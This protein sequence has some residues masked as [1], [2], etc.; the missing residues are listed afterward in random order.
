MNALLQFVRAR[1]PVVLLLVLLTGRLHA[2][3]VSEWPIP[4]TPNIQGLDALVPEDPT[5]LV[6]FT[7]YD[8]AKI[9][10]L[11]NISS[12]S[13]L[14]SEWFPIGTLNSFHPFKI[15]AGMWSFYSKANP[16]I[17]TTPPFA[18]PPIN[19]STKDLAAFV[20]AGSK[21]WSV[22]TFTMPDD[23]AIGMLIGSPFGPGPD[24]F[25]IWP[26]A[27][28]G[29]DQPWDIQRRN[30]SFNETSAWVSNRVP[31]QALYQFFPATS[32]LNKWD[33]GSCNFTVEVFYVVPA[34]TAKS[35]T[36][37]WIGG[38]HSNAAG[39]V[40]DAIAYMRVDKKN[41]AVTLMKIWDLPT[42]QGRTMDAIRFT[43]APTKD[44]FTNA[45]VWL[46]S[47]TVP[48]MTLLEPHSLYARKGI[49]SLC[50]TDTVSHYN[51]SNGLFWDD[52]VFTGLAG[53]DNARRM[54]ITGGEAGGAGVP[55]SVSMLTANRGTVTVPVQSTSC[56][57][58]M[59]PARVVLTPYQAERME[60]K[61]YDSSGTQPYQDI[62]PCNITRYIWDPTVGFNG[63]FAGG[64]LDIDMRGKATPAAAANGF[65]YS[66]IWHE[67]TTG[68]I[69]MLANS[70]IL[71]TLGPSN[72]RGDIQD[73]TS[74]GFKLSQ[75]YPNPFNPTTT[76]TYSLP[77]NARVSIKI[78]NTLGQEV[79]TLVNNEE[80]S[81]GQQQVVF[82]S[83]NFASGVY[84]YRLYAEKLSQDAQDSPTG[85]ILV[86]VKKMVVIK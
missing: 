52:P 50:V 3:M 53:T 26:T 46:S 8:K 48:E 36:E 86:D 64:L 18:N 21:F 19:L 22:A 66:I 25:W 17:L 14:L 35:F 15:V 69:G 71:L 55:N 12:G 68:R 80:K 24:Y 4:G 62:I 76:I 42:G 54:W 6:Y 1:I 84:Y 61:L 60:T 33:L 7:E 44:G 32:Q 34:P 16:G 51:G 73:Q 77:E 79:A 5:R 31:T 57:P 13:A 75:N 20:V 45:Q 27:P 38:K 37:V 78:Y 65:T 2:Q 28:A 74:G 56:A 43:H 70:P 72:Q 40:G 82:N 49:D 47:S 39:I 59:A 81:A 85:K 9:G 30:V 29:L 67:P 58:Q 83:Q 23:H 11:S 63:Q 10:M 41:L